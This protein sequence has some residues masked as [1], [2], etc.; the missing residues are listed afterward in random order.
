M[1]L[2]TLQ[3]C[4]QTHSLHVQLQ[5]PS[6]QS[7]IGPSSP[8]AGGPCTPPTRQASRPPRREI[9]RHHFACKASTHPSRS[10]Q[11][12][13]NDHH[14]TT[15]FPPRTSRNPTTLPSFLFTSY[16]STNTQHNTERCSAQPSSAPSRVWPPPLLRLPPRGHS[17]RGLRRLCCALARSPPLL[18]RGRSR[19][20]CGRTRLRAG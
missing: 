1:K 5:N 17:S 13:D 14:S 16:L 3:Q 11:L 4:S 10:R 12:L 15:P 9:Y 20:V 6:Q 2:V 8:A 19:S 18:R 7:G